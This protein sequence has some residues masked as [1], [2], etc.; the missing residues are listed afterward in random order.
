MEATLF[1]KKV[2]KGCPPL[3]VWPGFPFC[4]P[5]SPIFPATSHNRPCDSLRRLHF[6]IRI[7]FVFCFC[8]TERFFDCH[9]VATFYFFVFLAPPP[10]SY[11]P[12]SSICPDLQP[13]Q[14]RYHLYSAVH[15]S[16]PTQFFTLESVITS[17]MLSSNPCHRLATPP[18]HAVYFL[19]GCCLPNTVFKWL[20]GDE[21]NIVEKKISLP[22]LPREGKHLSRRD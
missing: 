18:R 7:S 12:C 5:P 8:P 2:Y 20:Y 3:W 22:P 4:L 13:I 10:V 19:A 1:V 16:C 6:I 14:V 15:T 17:P 11:I 21:L 9:S